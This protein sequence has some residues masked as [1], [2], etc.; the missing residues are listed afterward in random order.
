MRQGR[1]SNQKIANAKHDKENALEGEICSFCEQSTK[2]WKREREV[3]GEG[4]NQRDENERK[5]THHWESN[6]AQLLLFPS[7]LCLVV[8]S[9][10]CIINIIIDGDGELT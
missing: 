9:I 2:S 10:T 1:S 4:A 7:R 6:P 8:V 5:G 3:G